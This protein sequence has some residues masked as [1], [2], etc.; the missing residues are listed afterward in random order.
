MQ[1][2]MIA[3]GLAALLA[4]PGLVQAQ[5]VSP[6]SYVKLSAGE[7]SASTDFWGKDTDTTYGL[8]A[9]AQVSNNIDPAVSSA[10]WRLQAT[11]R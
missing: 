3:I 8:A 2:S 7:S 1:R 10:T 6:S 9:G 4:A 11:V 5:N